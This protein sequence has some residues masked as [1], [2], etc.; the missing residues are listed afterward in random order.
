LKNT[1][2]KA[3]KNMKNTKFDYKLSVTKSKV[4]LFRMLH[5]YNTYFGIQM[6]NQLGS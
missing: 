2:Q 3:L 4:I 1:I 6:S 5:L